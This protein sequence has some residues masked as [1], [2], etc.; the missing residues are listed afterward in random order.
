MLDEAETYVGMYGYRSFWPD[1]QGLISRA[2]AHATRDHRPLLADEKGRKELKIIERSKR[3]LIFV[4]SMNTEYFPDLAAASAEESST[5]DV[6]LGRGAGAGMA[7]SGAVM[8]ESMGRGFRIVLQVR[9]PMNEKDAASKLMK[10]LVDY[11]RR[12][13]ES[14]RK[15]D[16]DEPDVFKVASVMWTTSGD[17][18]D[19]D[20]GTGSARPHRGPPR[21]R[22]L[23]ADLRR[24]GDEVD[25]DTGPENPSALFPDEDISND[26]RFTITVLVEITADGTES[27][28]PARG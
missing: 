1:V 10:P 20:G 3:R 4:E 2:V 14:E 27:R 19:S 9:T 17:V 23:P 11:I 6:Y 24:G 26:T 12:S 13:A 16:K 21:G 28:K 22:G 25:E 5:D 18:A 15:N 8:P 7:Q